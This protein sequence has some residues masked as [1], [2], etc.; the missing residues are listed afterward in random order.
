MDEVRCKLKDCL[1]Y[2]K[3]G[4]IGVCSDYVPT[5]ISKLKPNDVNCPYYSDSLDGGL[6]WLQLQGGMVN[7][8]RNK[9]KKEKVE[10]L[11]PFE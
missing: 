10:K 8:V 11:M 4:R 1:N 3:V 5:M 7:A 9:N 2:E 6:R